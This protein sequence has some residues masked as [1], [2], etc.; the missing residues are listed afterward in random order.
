MLNYGILLPNEGH[1]FRSIAVRI[2]DEDY[3]LKLLNRQG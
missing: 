2:L 1:R 3:L